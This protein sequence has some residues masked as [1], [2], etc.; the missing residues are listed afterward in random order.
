MWFGVWL[1]VPELHYEK[2][3]TMGKELRRL[4]DTV[5]QHLQDLKSMD[6][7]PSGRFITSIIELKLECKY[8]V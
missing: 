6:Y 2:L 1:I 7:E 5:Q 8:Q 3:A 4:H